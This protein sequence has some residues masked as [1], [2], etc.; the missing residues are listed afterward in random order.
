MIPMM[1]TVLWLMLLFLPTAAAAR[2]GAPPQTSGVRAVCRAGQTF[3]TWQDAQD[4]F[5][6]GPVTWG[7]I[8]DR[9][10][11]V[12]YRV[13][14]HNKPIDA[15]SLKDA[16]LL[17][18]VQPL[19]GFN[20]HSW[21]FERLVN[22]AVFSHEDKGELARYDHFKGWDRDSP[23][24][25]KLIIP[26][27]A[28]E[29]HKLLPAATGLYV[30]SASKQ[31][32]AYYAVTAV[33]DGQEN[34]TFTAGNSP[35]QPVEEKVQAWQPVEQPDPGKFGFDFRGRRHYFVA[36]V[37]APLAPK[38]MY[39]NWSVLVPPD[40]KAPV[41]VELYFHDPGMSYARPPTK[42][43]DRSIQ[44]C[45]HDFPFSGWYGYNDA[46]AAGKPAEAGV[47]RPHT[48]RRIAAFLQWAQGRFPADPS[49][50]MAVGGDGA[51]MMALHRPELIACVFITR[52]QAQQL[53]S[54]SAEAFAGCWGPASPQIKDEAGRGEWGW[55][56]FDRLLCG[57]KL[58]NVPKADELAAIEPNP[59][60]P[61][62]QM[63]LPMF[64][65]S[66]Y[67]WGR[68]PDYG[69][70]RGRLY[71]ALQATRQGLCA[72]WAWGGK[73]PAPSKFAG[74]WRGIDFTNSS[75]L[76]VITRSSNDK[77]GEGAGNCNLDYSW[78]QVAEDAGSFEVA[79]SGRPGTFDLTPRRL[80]KLKIAP[81]QK[82][83]WEVV[84][85][86]SNPRGTVPDEQSGEVSA[87]A[88]GVLT[89]PGLQLARE[90]S[91]KVRIQTTK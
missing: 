87:D 40:C 82:L 4:D 22:Q 88:H 72:D 3:I 17:A 64:I 30:H 56:E 53:D 8:R 84:S 78:S 13:Y 60:Y 38:P 34:K 81:N 24:G 51:A 89:L 77:E 21:S 9:K 15:E 68:D 76:P 26:R 20:V 28:I 86:P 44:V 11:S 23:Q 2:A 14:R 7:Q 41:P 29:D 6:A 50:V 25:G 48:I 52:F 18:E 69:H 83:Q 33:D 59:A 46:V 43:L 36:W 91:L 85:I 10:S 65:C 5:G 19:S 42:L 54:K 79:I 32:T 62:H 67:S 16:R 66:S 45:P 70:G 61:G 27:F 31:E 55:G 80:S 73:L 35:A 37:A 49:R 90:A 63:N 47:V 75:P 57:R 39:F 58:P 71:Y 1:K 12:R 74:T